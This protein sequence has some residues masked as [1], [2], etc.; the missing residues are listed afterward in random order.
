MYAL[1]LFLATLVGWIMLS[2]WITEK[3]KDAPFCQNST[4]TIPG[5]SGYAVDCQKAAG[6]LA[7]YRLMFALTIFFLIFM[8]IMFGVKSSKDSR[9]SIQNG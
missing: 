2:P 7:V 8:V 9:S 1:M 3:M 4:S 6:Y 5:V